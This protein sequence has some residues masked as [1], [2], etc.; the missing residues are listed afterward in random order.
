MSFDEQVYAL[1]REG[2]Q[3][4]AAAVVP[5]LYA[6][7]APTSV[8]DVGGGE[9]WWGQEFAKIGGVQR[10]SVFD[11]TAQA[12]TDGKVAYVPV[13]LEQPGM[14][15]T[16]GALGFDLALCL[17]VAEHVHPTHA[18]ALIAGL[19]AL[20]PII[21]FSAAIPSQGGHGHVN[22]QW[23]G[24]WYGKF[25]S[26]AFDCYDPRMRFWAD[27]EIEPWYRQN[28]LVYVRRGWLAGLPDWT[29]GRPVDL[30]HPYF[31]EWRVRERDE[32]WPIR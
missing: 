19:C 4:S 22:E 24:Y 14:L 8:A 30:V 13:D 31:Y 16:W 2:C 29:F 10:V 25:V 15:A 5:H 18:D 26:H 23:T 28:L 27:E 11:S 20:A 12:R 9:G 17:E 1:L 6:W 21:V 32:S 3:R 7:F